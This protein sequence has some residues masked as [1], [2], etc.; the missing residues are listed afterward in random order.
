M[1]EETDFRARTVEEVNREGY[2]FHVPDYQRGYRWTQEQVKRL[3]DDLADWVPNTPYS[4]QP[5]IVHKDERKAD[6]LDVVDGQQRLTTIAL[7]LGQDAKYTLRYETRE[8]TSEFLKTLCTGT[9]PYPEQEIENLFGKNGKLKQEDP[10]SHTIDN[11]HLLAA[12][13]AINEWKAVDRNRRR[14]EDARKTLLNAKLLWYQITENPRIVFA[15]INSGKIQLSDADLIKATLLKDA[16]KDRTFISREW[17][18]IEQ[19]LADDSFWAFLGQD[20]AHE[21][22]RIEFL[23]RI[24][25]PGNDERSDGTHI[26]YNRC[27]QKYAGNAAGGTFHD[28]WREIWDLYETL[29]EWYQANPMYHRIGYLSRWNTSK[30]KKEFNVGEAY[31]K[32]LDSTKNDFV[33]WLDRN[34]LD[35]LL[36]NIKDKNGGLPTDATEL[37]DTVAYGET[38]NRDIEKVLLLFNLPIVPND[39][40]PRE[41]S[42]T[43]VSRYRYPF[44]LH[45][46]EKWSVEHIHAQSAKK[47]KTEEE[48]R[49][50]LQAVKEMLEATGADDEDFG[51]IRQEV[52]QMLL[53][54][55]REQDDNIQM[56]TPDTRINSIYEKIEEAM[57]DRKDS[58]DNLALLSGTLN[59]S[60]GNGFFFEKRR[61]IIAEDKAGRFIPRETRNGFLK[62]Y[63]NSLSG[64]LWDTEDRDHYIKAIRGRLQKWF[65]MR[66]EK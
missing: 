12:F 58:L 65:D 1:P 64:A 8:E 27:I 49:D 40:P 29:L 24:I 4:L 36:S 11:F 14:F 18:E 62:Y 45:L 23:F 10:K 46:R 61:K 44:D 47:P 17:D 16:P 13:R 37:T 39:W 41:G 53:D 63:S 22:N 21:Y 38:A 42:S 50:Y 5:V 57:R 43:E 34:I 28:L 59:T 20:L 3:L 6:V 60:I 30:G 48:I 15:R 9:D 26:L 19:R 35:V 51:T 33:G 32:Y 7:I 55:D 2:T 25:V 56:A 31:K 52:E 66:G 54:L